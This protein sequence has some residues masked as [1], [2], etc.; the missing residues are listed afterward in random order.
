MEQRQVKK[1]E[2]EFYINCPHCKKEIK[3]KTENQVKYNLDI[4]IRAKHK[5][6]GYG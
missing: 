3:G 2:T 1:E 5:E 4:H 6:E